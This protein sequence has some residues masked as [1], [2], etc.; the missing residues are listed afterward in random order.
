MLTTARIASMTLME[1]DG[2]KLDRGTSKDSMTTSQ[3]HSPAY[4]DLDLSQAHSEEEDDTTAESVE[5]VNPAYKHSSVPIVPHHARHL[6]QPS[7]STLKYSRPPAVSRHRQSIAEDFQP[8]RIA[9][10][11]LQMPAPLR[12][13]SFPHSQTSPPSPTHPYTFLAHFP[14]PS[15]GQSYDASPAPSSSSLPFTT[16]D[17]ATHASN[18]PI[19]APATPR[20]PRKLQ[21][22][23]QSGTTTPVEPESPRAQNETR[24]WSRWKGKEADGMTTP[25]PTRTTSLTHDSIPLETTSQPHPRS[26]NPFFA[27]G[28]ALHTSPE[29]TPPISPAPAEAHER[30]YRPEPGEVELLMYGGDRARQGGEWDGATEAARTA[31]AVAARERPPLTSRPRSALITSIFGKSPASNEAVPQRR[32]LQRKHTRS[33]SAAPLTRHQDSTGLVALQYA[34]EPERNVVTPSPLPF[35]HVA[36]A[37]LSEDLSSDEDNEDDKSGR[38][39]QAAVRSEKARSRELTKA[40]LIDD[41]NEFFSALQGLYA[42]ELDEAGRETRS[43]FI[44]RELLMTERSY[45]R[46]LARL[47]KVRDVFRPYLR[48]S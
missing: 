11:P 27:G 5:Q 45:A 20:R 26:S 34:D 9:P 2:V 42:S 19:L 17:T 6:S 43:A 22:K 8:L 38:I 46:H 23:R 3:S 10:P 33:N 4:S 37:I 7:M 44:V 13:H 25:G 16:S 24:R 40:M 18:E 48:A 21:R 1:E 29:P 39:W 30:W 31:K 32:K 35:L 28:T 14:Y 47:L 12:P 15:Y 36:A 41:D